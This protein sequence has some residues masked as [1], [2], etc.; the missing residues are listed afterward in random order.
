MTRKVIKA[1]AAEKEA[2]AKD[3]LTLYPLHGYVMVDGHR[4]PLEDLRGAWSRPD[5]VWEL[6]APAGY[7]F[8]AGEMTH[9]LLG[10]T[11]ADAIDRAW[12]L[13]PCTETCGGE[14]A[15]WNS[16]D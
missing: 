6:L 13:E 5:P 11:Q 8:G 9:S 10:Y 2:Y 16:N 4:C 14:P 12:C 1:T 15:P 7:H 3:P